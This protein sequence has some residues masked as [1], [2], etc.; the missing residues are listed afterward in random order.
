M[1]TR[2]RQTGDFRWINI[3]TPQPDGLRVVIVA[4]GCEG[5]E[6]YFGSVSANAVLTY[7]KNAETAGMILIR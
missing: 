7:L 3:L 4:A 5:D 1:S 2:A 6:Y